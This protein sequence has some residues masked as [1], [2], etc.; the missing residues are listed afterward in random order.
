MVPFYVSGSLLPPRDSQMPAFPEPQNF[1]RWKHLVKCWL[2]FLASGFLAKATHGGTAVKPS[3][4]CQLL[5]SGCLNISP[6]F[7]GLV[8]NPEWSYF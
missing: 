6:V 7:P 2:V 3:A 4:T 8:K 1:P 5:I